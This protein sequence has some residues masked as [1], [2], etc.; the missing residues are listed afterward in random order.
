MWGDGE[1]ERQASP[2]EVLEGIGILT[3][4]LWVIG[5]SEQRR[6]RDGTGRDG[7]GRGLVA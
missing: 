2:S 6:R 4:S 5:V 3:S 1:R 7:T